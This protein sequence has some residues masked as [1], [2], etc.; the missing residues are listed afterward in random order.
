MIK[1]QLFCV[2][3]HTRLG[4]PIPIVTARDFFERYLTIEIWLSFTFLG[5]ANFIDSDNCKF[6]G[7]R[8]VYHLRRGGGVSIYFCKNS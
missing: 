2:Q 8:P 7:Q 5:C 1:H 4:D 3:Q 6:L